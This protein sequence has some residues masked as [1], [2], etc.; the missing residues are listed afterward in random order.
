MEG[1]IMKKWGIGKQVIILTVLMVV[2]FSVTSAHSDLIYSTFGP[3]Q[4]FTSTGLIVGTYVH[5]VTMYTVL[6]GVPFIPSFDATLDSIDFAAYYLGGSNTLDVSLMSDSAGLPGSPLETF[7]FTNTIGN[8]GFIYTANSVLDV[9]LTAGTQYWIVLSAQ[10]NGYFAWNE[11]TNLAH[12]VG[13]KYLQGGSD[14]NWHV[15]SSIYT[16]AFD[17]NGTPPTQT[18]QP[19]PEPA[20]M[21][22][23]GSGLIGLAGYGRKK[24]FKK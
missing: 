20:T 14:T 21:L 15:N 6:Q 22:L 24:F 5:Q 9:P 4:S 16:P 10:G 11:N 2:V 23:L 18:T 7:T 12:D 3:G 13:L 8:S 1:N 17:V 19:V